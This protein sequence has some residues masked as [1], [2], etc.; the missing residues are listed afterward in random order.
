MNKFEKWF[1]K[2]IVKNEVRQGY[3]HAKRIAAL[4]EIIKDATT[5]EFTEDNTTTRNMFLTELFVD[6]LNEDTDPLV[7]IEYN[8]RPMFAIMP[9]K[10]IS[11]K[12]I[13]LEKCAIRKVW[14][15][16]F[17]PEPYIEYGNVFDVLRD[18][19]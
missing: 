8:W 14:R 12:W 11:G 19:Y 4:Y 6:S 15:G 13:W 2:K 3:D 18:K 7:S 16:N 5:R 9:H 10:S 17:V 1:F